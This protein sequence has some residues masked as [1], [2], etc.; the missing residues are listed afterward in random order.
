MLVWRVF[1]NFAVDMDTTQNTQQS[2]SLALE[3]GNEEISYLVYG[4]DAALEHGTIT[5]DSSLGNYRQALENAVYDNEFLL[6]D[7]A[8]T[9][10]AIHSQHFQLIPQEL[11]QAGMTRKVMDASFTTV[12]GELLTCNIDGS[13]AAIVCDIPSG[14][15]PFLRRTFSGATLLHHLA[16][17]C[18][19]CIKAYAEDTACMH[20]AIYDHDSHIV[21]I[22]QGALYMANTFQYRA[23]EDVAYYA[24]NMWKSCA[25]T[26]KRDKV[27]LSGDNS[28]RTQLAEQLRQWIA[29]VMPEVLPTQA[30]QLGRDATILPFNL[31]TLAL[32]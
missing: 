9:K 30:L 2:R 5:L 28:L 26:S 29:Y 10:I 3:I 19:Y 12:D 25:L 24:L 8:S 18:S 6:E 17:L 16:S 15:L 31:I 23:I 1:V 14:I 4:G 27:M 22:K 32:Y 20:I 13:D 7:Y 11:I 21:V